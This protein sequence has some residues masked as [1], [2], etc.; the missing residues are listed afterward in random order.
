MS[1]LSII[2]AGPSLSPS[3]VSVRLTDYSQVVILGPWYRSVNFGGEKSP[4][5]PRWWAQI[6]SDRA[7]EKR[8]KL[9]NRAR[10]KRAKLAS[11]NT[12]RQTAIGATGALMNRVQQPRTLLV[13]GLNAGMSTAAGADERKGSNSNRLQGY[14]A[15]P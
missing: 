2:S 5:E 7:R 8:A 15:F 13:L 10:E 4:D 9:A 6:D 11:P 14:L 12:L 3:S 1:F